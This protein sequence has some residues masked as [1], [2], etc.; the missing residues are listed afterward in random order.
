MRA[1]QGIHGMGA[2]SRVNDGSHAALFNG[3]PCVGLAAF[4]LRKEDATGFSIL[5]ANHAMLP[6]THVISKSQTEHGLP[7]IIAVK[8]KPESINNAGAFVHQNEGGRRFGIAIGIWLVAA[9]N[10]PLL[11]F[12]GARCRE[13]CGFVFVSRIRDTM[14]RMLLVCIEPSVGLAMWF[15]STSS[16]GW[17][18]SIRV[19]KGIWQVIMA[20]KPLGSRF[21]VFQAV[22]SNHAVVEAVEALQVV[23][24]HILGRIQA[25]VIDGDNH[26]LNMLAN[27]RGPKLLARVEVHQRGM[28]DNILGDFLEYLATLLRIPL[29]VPLGAPASWAVKF[30]IFLPGNVHTLSQFYSQL[31][32]VFFGVFFEDG[33]EHGRVPSQMV[34]TTQ[35]YPSTCLAIQEVWATADPKP[36]TSATLR[37]SSCRIEDNREEG[38]NGD[39]E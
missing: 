38:D 14:D 28:V 7:E 1:G 12:A 2:N 26:V 16:G 39:D 18:R 32:G 24:R 33:R 29:H 17:Y 19:I 4:M 10:Y 5:E 9:R 27:V 35:A 30:S 37:S 11:L 13:I 25:L 36:V 31:V 22:K 21:H 15:S 34:Q 6:V 3:R 20:V 23:Q 8:E